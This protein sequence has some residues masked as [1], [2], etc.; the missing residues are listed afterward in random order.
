MIT[1]SAA[2]HTVR[3][4]PRSSYRNTTRPEAHAWGTERAFDDGHGTDSAHVPR[5][6]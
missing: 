2:N 5:G 1:M 3:W 4:A 6:R